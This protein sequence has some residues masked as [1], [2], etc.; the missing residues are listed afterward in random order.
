MDERPTRLITVEEFA[1]MTQDDDWTEE[2]IDGVI[3]RSP[4][5]YMPHGAACGNLSFAV[6]EYRRATKF[7]L[8]TIGSGLVV[9]RNPDSV[10][11][12]DLQLFS[13][14]RP[15][16]IRKGWPTVPPVLVAEVVDRVSDYS[17]VMSKVPYY[18][19]FGVDLVW[20]VKPA[21]KCVE[22]HRLPDQPMPFDRYQWSI[23]GYLN[24]AIRG[25]HDLLE[26]GDVLPGFSCK[27]SDLF[28]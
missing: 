18:L 16:D 3:H 25:Q 22:I 24:G 12:P 27:V 7:G 21:I 14:P 15:P 10:L 1:A 9:A 17:H 8:A 19:A 6:E 11:A 20:I 2:L 28:E 26:G 23:A 4:P 5:G 13:A